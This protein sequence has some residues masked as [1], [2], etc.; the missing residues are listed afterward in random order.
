MTSLVSSGDILAVILFRDVLQGYSE[1]ERCTKESDR[2]DT[3]SLAATM[4]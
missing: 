2:G 3:S 1:I 4:R